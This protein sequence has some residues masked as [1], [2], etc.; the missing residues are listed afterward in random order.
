MNEGAPNDLMSGT[1]KSRVCEVEARL[2][3]PDVHRD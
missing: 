2:V 1:A 3:V